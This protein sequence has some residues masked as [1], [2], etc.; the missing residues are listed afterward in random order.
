MRV[1]CAVIL[2]V[3]AATASKGQTSLSE[4]TGYWNLG[5]SWVGGTMPGSTAGST[6]NLA[7]A[8]VTINGRILSR[9][10]IS[11]SLSSISINAGDT[12]V[13]LGN[14]TL[15]TSTLTNNGVLIV[16]G[17]MYNTTSTSTIS[18]S[19]KLVVTGN[20]IN[21]LGIN[22]FTGPS[23]IYGSTSGFLL[24]PGVEDRDDLIAMDPALYS[25][26]NN[27]YVILPVT[28]L[29]FYAEEVNGHVKLSWTTASELNSDHFLVERSDDGINFSVLMTVGA[30]GNSKQKIFYEEVDRLPLAGKS[31]YRLT[32]V[33]Y[34]GSATV[35]KVV[36]VYDVNPAQVVPYPNPTSDFLHVNVE[37]GKYLIR[38]SDLSGTTMPVD[39]TP[40]ETDPRQLTV[41]M[42]TLTPGIY[43]MHLIN[44]STA[45]DVAY[46][47]VKN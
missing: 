47:I 27:I 34:D 35:L 19:G 38:L 1:I 45:S 17:N 13:V 30:A 26:V 28:L 43:I 15:T 16:F 24:S 37:T 10:N 33:D 3:I 42:R 41:D 11:A 31:Y 18:G 29:D 9:Y 40:S 23:Y 8:G 46:K 32:Q 36:V 21:S 25:Y 39:F 12:L 6:I 2:F 4:K 5:A 14:L 20:Y 44:K 7:L 22:S